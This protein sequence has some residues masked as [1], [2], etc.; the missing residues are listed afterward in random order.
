MKTGLNFVAT[1]PE[2]SL[3]SKLACADFFIL[4][5]TVHVGHTKYLFV[6]EG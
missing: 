6:C 1:Y 4:F 3:V 5:V 2:L